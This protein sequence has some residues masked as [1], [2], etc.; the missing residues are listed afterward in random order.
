MLSLREKMTGFVF[1]AFTSGTS[2]GVAASW[3][4]VISFLVCFFRYE[5]YSV[6]A[7][8]SAPSLQIIP[9]E[10]TH[11][12]SYLAAGWNNASKQ[13]TDTSCGQKVSLVS[14]CRCLGLLQ[15][16]NKLD[17]SGNSTTTFRCFLFNI[18]GAKI[19]T[20]TGRG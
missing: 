8:N 10:N 16:H 1:P 2:R 12:L 15:P 19:H 4:N 18:I 14:L 13:A 7:P 20:S 6:P 17:E 5:Y 11:K 3:R 9:S